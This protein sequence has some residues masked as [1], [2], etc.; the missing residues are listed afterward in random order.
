MAADS[1]PERIASPVPRQSPS[2]GTPASG[3]PAAVTGIFVLLVFYTLYFAAPVLMPITLAVV[4]SLVLSPVVSHLAAWRIPRPLA[5]ACVILCLLGFLSAGIYVLSEPAARW[6]E[7]A[8]QNLHQVEGKLKARLQEPLTALE[9]AYGKFAQITGLETTGPSQ[10][11]K[12]QRPS[13]TR[14]LISSTHE[15]IGGIGGVVV[16]FALLFFLL[17]SPGL[18][19]KVLCLIPNLNNKTR[20][21]RI[22]LAIEHDVTLYLFTITLINIGLGAATAVAL[23]FL[24]VPNPL[25]W[26][27]M[28]MLFNFAPYVGASVSF[29]VLAFVS[30]LSFDSLLHA[31]LVPV[32]FL[33]LALLEGQF[34]TPAIVGKR[35]NLS[36]VLVFLSVFIWG[37]MWGMAGM[38]LAVPL[39]ASLKIVCERVEALHPLGQFLS[40]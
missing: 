33:A 19:R 40:R 20:A 10:P 23:H 25:L 6:I 7:M 1:D 37:W 28:V 30:I 3:S 13:L 22:A 14:M 12:I 15:V 17:A 35:L 2:G 38:L 9:Q 8:P 31:L 11:F 24:G 16:I 5:A 18:T 29:L 36:P 34:L 26:G 32:A 21:H 4:L 27:T 39:L